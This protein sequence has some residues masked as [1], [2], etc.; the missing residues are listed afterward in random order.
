MTAVGPGR[1]QAQLFL[2]WTGGH[3]STSHVPDPRGMRLGQTD[4]L[5]L[6]PGTRS[7]WAIGHV[8]GP[9]GEA[10]GGSVL[11]RGAIWRYNP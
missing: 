10:G 7:L 2:H 5:A 4:E 9:S 1:K 6:I 3:C 8:Y 11:N